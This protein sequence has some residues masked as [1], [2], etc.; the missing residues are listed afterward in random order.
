MPA[1]PL[2][3]EALA[4][5]TGVTPFLERKPRPVT[6]TQG[7]RAEKL[8]ERSERLLRRFLK[9]PE[10]QRQETEL[11][12]FDYFEALDMLT[13]PIDLDAMTALLANMEDHDLML[14]FL[15]VLQRGRAFLEAEIP[16]VV[17]TRLFGPKNLEPDDYSLARFRRQWQAVNA[18]EVVLGDLAE[19]TLVSDQVE[20]LEAV[21]PALLAAWRQ[22]V[23]ALG[24][25]LVAEDEDW[26]PTWAKE[27]VLARF[28]GAPPEAPPSAVDAAKGAARTPEPPAAAGQPLD[29]NISPAGAGQ[30]STQRMEQR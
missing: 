25:E 28:L 17:E 12:A 2:A 20:A 14:A 23:Q 15:D 24:A 3:A 26:A 16:R 27:Q 11:P 1:S 19:G 8:P 21:Y 18:P 7:A 6:P 10:F 4:A 9:G 22:Q 30:T 13:Q 5:V 29:I